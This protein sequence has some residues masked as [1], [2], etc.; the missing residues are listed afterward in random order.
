MRS[1]TSL[2][3][4]ICLALGATIIAVIVDPLYALGLAL[5]LFGM[6]LLSRND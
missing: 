5:L 3:G 4:A 2:A 1:L 6:A